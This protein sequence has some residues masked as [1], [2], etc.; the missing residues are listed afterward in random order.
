MKY[1]CK[2]PLVLDLYDDDG[3]SAEGQKYVEVGEA[4]E[5]A[6]TSFRVAGGPDTI[7]LENAMGWME[8]LPE[9][10]GEY[11]EEAKEGEQ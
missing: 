11:F 6:E 1:R 5:V 8:L 9:T 4:F 3:F 2:K 7:R 10:I